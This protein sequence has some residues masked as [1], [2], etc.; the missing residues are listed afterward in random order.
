[1]LNVSDQTPQTSS[2]ANW[3]SQLGS[4]ANSLG[5]AAGSV[6][7]GLNGNRPTSTTTGLQTSTN[8]TPILL[9]GGAVVGLVVIVAMVRK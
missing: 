3:L 1:M 8:W 6:L 2:S 9:I 5:S 7:G 4:F